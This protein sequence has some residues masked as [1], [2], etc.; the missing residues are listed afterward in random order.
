MRYAPRDRPA[1]GPSGR[2]RGSAGSS[3]ASRLRR[4]SSSLSCSIRRVVL[5]LSRVKI[6]AEE[7]VRSSDVPWSIVRATGFYWLVERM[8]ANV[9]K[10]QPVLLPAHARMQPVDADDF[11]EFVVQCV[12]DRGR[13][14]REDFAGPEVLTMRELAEQY[15]AA[16]SLRRRI[17]SVP[18]P[19]LIQSALTA[20]STAH[21]G[22]HGATTWSE[23]LRRSAATNRRDD[24][25]RP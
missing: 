24:R 5:V 22:R 19:R 17:W 13:G 16:Q 25:P 20:G 23:W 8:L 9:V 2:T 15:L 7:L 6:A 3:V 10:R 18:V 14:E 4:S 1:R 11:A 21:T 12:R